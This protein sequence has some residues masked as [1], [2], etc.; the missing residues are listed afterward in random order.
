MGKPLDVKEF[1]TIVYNKDFEKIDGYECIEKE[2]F[3][4][5]TA[6]IRE[7]TGDEENAD[8]QDF[9]RIS[10]K[11]PAGEYIKIQNYVGLIQL[12]TGFQIQVLPKI[13][14]SNGEDKN[15]E[16]TKK[17]FLK[18][19]RSMKD[20]PG[21]VFHS[22]SLNVDKMNLYELFINMYLQDVRVLVKHGLKSAYCEAADCLL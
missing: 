21:K 18:M 10:Y 20:F 3:D 17:V 19:L 1:D 15:N 16:E 4:S 13:S 2:Q 12:K 22:A 14:F 7:F 5:L 9:M 6:F 11:R 8:V